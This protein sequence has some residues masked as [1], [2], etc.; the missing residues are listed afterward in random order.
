MLQPEHEEGN[1]CATMNFVTVQYRI[2]NLWQICFIH[3]QGFLYISVFILHMIVW[4]FF[5]TPEYTSIAWDDFV[6]ILT[7]YVPLSLGVLAHPTNF[8]LVWNILGNY[9]GSTAMTQT[10]TQQVAAKHIHRV[11]WRGIFFD[12][13]LCFLNLSQMHSFPTTTPSG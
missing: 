8:T 11:G 9:F 4:E 12:P 7:M 5:K 10:R 13:K 2:L 6:Q 1:I 3:S